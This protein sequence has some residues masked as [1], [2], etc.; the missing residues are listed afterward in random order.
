MKDR[1]AN[2]K[3]HL[4]TQIDTAKKM[5]SKWVY[6]LVSE[7]EKCLELAEAEDTLLMDPVPAEIEGDGK[8]EWWYVCG[9]CHSNL[10]PHDKYCRECGR[11]MKWLTR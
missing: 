4:K 11:K 6:I 8:S 5:D 10:N 2:T 9:E 3:K 7:A 1:L